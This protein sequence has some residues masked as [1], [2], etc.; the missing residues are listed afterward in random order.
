MYTTEFIADKIEFISSKDSAA[1]M[2]SVG[3]NGTE[4]AP[5]YEGF[6]EID[7]AELPF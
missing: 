7:D 3:D 6:T 5:D 1:L 2:N 4:A